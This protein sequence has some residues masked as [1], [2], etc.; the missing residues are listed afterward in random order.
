[1]LISVGEQ[2][3]R[4]PCTQG[5]G[6]F[7]ALQCAGVESRLLVF[8]D[9]GHLIVKPGN[10]LRWYEETVGWMEKFVG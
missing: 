4:V 10:K 3:R 1:M 2:D 7:A 9:E 5:M 6:A 8:P